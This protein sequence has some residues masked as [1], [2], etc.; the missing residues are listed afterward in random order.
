MAK[1]PNETEDRDM[2]GTSKVEQSLGNNTETDVHFGTRLTQPRTLFGLR[3]FLH[4]YRIKAGDDVARTVRA[5][6]IIG[7]IDNG[8]VG[9]WSRRAA[10]ELAELD[11]SLSWLPA[12]KP[13]ERVAAITV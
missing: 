13:R 3:S 9:E 11:P 6:I 12:W 7:C 4:G 5:S 10:R 8:H 1:K 2:T